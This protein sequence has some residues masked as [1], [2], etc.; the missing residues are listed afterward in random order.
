MAKI[1]LFELKEKMATL[2][3]AIRADAEW[4]A[5]KAADP[6]TPIKEVNEKTAHRDELQA[7]FDLLKKEHDDMEAAQKAQVQK[8]AEATMDEKGARI[9]AKADFYRAALS[10]DRGAMKKSYEGLG[11]IPGADVDLGNGDK[12]LP[13]NMS[14]E[15][16]TEPQEDNPLRTVCRVTNIAGLEEPKLGFVIE[17]EDLEDVTDK[18][19]AK[20]IELSGDTVVY[21]RHKA[22]VSATI[23]ETVLHGSDLDLVN[24]VE[25]GLKSALAKREKLYAFQAKAKADSDEGHKH[26]SFYSTDSG[27]KEV[28]GD[29]T[30]D[31]IVSAY[32][33]LADEFAANAT[34]FMKKDQYYKMVKELTN[35]SEALFGA[36]PASILGIP[37]KFCDRAESPVVGDF[38]YYGMNYE[39]GS[40]F[41]TDKDV[42]K[43]EYY[44]VLT[45]WGDQQIRLKS[46]FRIAK[47]KE[48]P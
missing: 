31:A 37:V 20:E 39:P 10:G 5:E 2:Q 46:A 44:F 8:K 30:Y 48:N 14:S 23:K 22:K 7:R 35:D 9:K 40:I 13:T 18:E 26:M 38:S 4:I 1:T 24:A 6:T 47:V 21:G 11:A 15:L 36:K 32:A 34:V 43:G 16:I 42:K 29:T 27:I 19:T 12:L 25:G 33:D 17:D 45:A 28:E 3:A 41:D